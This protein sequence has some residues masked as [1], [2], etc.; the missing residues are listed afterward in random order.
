M[1]V[2]R[3]AL[4]TGLWTGVGSA[5]GVGATMAYILSSSRITDLTRNDPML[6]DKTYARYNP[7]GNP[8]LTDVVTKRVPLSKI[9]PELRDNEEA[10]TL[11]FCRGIWSRWGFWPQSKYQYKY[12]RPA[13]TDDN[14]WDIKDLGTANFDRG[15]RIVNHFE[16]VDKRPTEI[17]IR[18]GGSPL[19]PGLRKSDGLIVLGARIDRAAQEAEFTFKSALFS[20]GAPRQASDA[21]HSVPPKIVTLHQWYVKILTQSALARVKA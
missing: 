8:A 3:T 17:W 13:N 1:G 4:M 14:L 11:E 2:L 21:K 9:K 7:R 15:L 20:S 19:E 16:V 6:W 18:C 10:L 12:D 5:A